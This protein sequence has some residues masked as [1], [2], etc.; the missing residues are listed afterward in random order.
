MIEVS[1]TTL[2][3]LAAD[4]AEIHARHAQQYAEEAEAA[5]NL[6][7]PPWSTRTGFTRPIPAA[8]TGWRRPMMSASTPGLAVS[9]VR[10]PG[11]RP[12]FSGPTT[13]RP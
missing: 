10:P 3:R 12:T 4:S 9:P 6:A 1:P 11:P 5:P 7:V 8:V 2:A 13:P